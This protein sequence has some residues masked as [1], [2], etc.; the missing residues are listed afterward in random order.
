MRQGAR[1]VPRPV[2]LPHVPVLDRAQ[3][4]VH[5]AP[6]DA[7]VPVELAQV[8][9]ALRQLPVEQQVLLEFHYWHDLD[10]GALA[11]MFE[12]SPG[13]IRVRLLRARQAL[14]HRLGTTPPPIGGD[15]LS[16]AL[17]EPDGD[18]AGDPAGDPE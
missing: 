3:R 10:A 17:S 8:R 16:A 15:P 6:Q 5:A 14:R 11:Q 7:Q 13:A 12:A 9:A 2:D 18:P 1:P 4:A